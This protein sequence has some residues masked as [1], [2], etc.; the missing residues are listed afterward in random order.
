MPKHTPT[1]VDQLRFPCCGHEHFGACATDCPKCVEDAKPEE[2]Q[3]FR[4]E[5]SSPTGPFGGPDPRR[6]PYPGDQ[7]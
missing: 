6:G 5:S 3:R 1:A 4:S 2:G 7:S